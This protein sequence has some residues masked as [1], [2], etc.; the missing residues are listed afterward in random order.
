[1]G[2]SDLIVGARGLFHYEF[3]ENLD[4]YAGVMLG[5]DVKLYPQKD[6]DLPGSKLYPGFF[7]GARYYVTNNFG[8]FG[9]VGLN[10]A[11]LEV[12]VCYIF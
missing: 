9:E 12:G 11:P 3:L 1:L 8:F 6:A 5:F 7:L 10:S 2:V 4:T